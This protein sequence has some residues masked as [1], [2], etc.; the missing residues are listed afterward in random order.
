MSK[1]L[2][3]LVSSCYQ[4]KGKTILG[5]ISTEQAMVFARQLGTLS[6]ISSRDR[7]VFFFTDSHIFGY[8][9]LPVDFVPCTS[10]FPAHVTPR[11]GVP[12]GVVDTPEKLRSVFHRD[13]RQ[14]TTIEELVELIDATPAR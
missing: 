8:P 6:T 7:R 3:N 4:V 11:P 5:V 13:Q 2:Q 14:I 1:T 10:V 9:H 12:D